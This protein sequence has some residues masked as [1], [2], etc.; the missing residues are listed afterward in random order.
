MQEISTFPT[1]KEYIL[2]E[3]PISQMVYERLYPESVPIKQKQN[4]FLTQLFNIHKLVP[5][6][7]LQSEQHY[8]SGIEVELLP[9]YQPKDD[10]DKTLIFESRFE[11]GNLALALKRS[12]C[13]YDLFM[14]NDINTR[15]H[16]QWF[17]FRASNT[18]KGKTV[19]FNIKNFVFFRF[20]I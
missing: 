18:Q 12:E 8:Y 17:F 19:T 6:E 20:Y 1:L 2:K 7:S 14:Q 4:M 15:G 3:L 5:S 16:T 10:M 13:E 11:S 9:Y